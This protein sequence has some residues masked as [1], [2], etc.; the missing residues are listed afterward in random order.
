MTFGYRPSD[1]YLSYYPLNDVSNGTMACVCVC[2][3]VCVGGMALSCCDVLV[4]FKVWRN[5]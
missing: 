4:E 2:V 3:C 1:C 5:N